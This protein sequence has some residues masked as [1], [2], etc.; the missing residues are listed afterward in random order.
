MKAG[1]PEEK[2]K[3]AVTI[4]EAEQRKEI[5]EEPVKEPTREKVHLLCFFNIGAKLSNAGE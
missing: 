2:S 4:E 5:T 1:N 3:E